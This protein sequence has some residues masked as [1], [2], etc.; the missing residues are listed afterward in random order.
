MA[1]K[2][3]ALKVVKKPSATKKQEATPHSWA[4]MSDRER[5]LAVLVPL[6]WHTLNLITNEIENVSGGAATA[7][8]IA[9]MKKDIGKFYEGDYRDDYEDGQTDPDADA[10]EALERSIYDEITTG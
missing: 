7:K 9:L 8:N 6:A 5:R 10:R 2:K 1:A 4:T 3:T